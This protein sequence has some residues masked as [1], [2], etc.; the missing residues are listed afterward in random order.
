V[1]SEKKTSVLIWSGLAASVAGIV[2]VVACMR[3][4]ERNRGGGASEET[5]YRDVKE[6]LSDVHAKIEEIERQLPSPATASNGR[7]TAGK[8]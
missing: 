8:K 6:V 5:H 4:Q 7:T 2:A 3:W 1:T